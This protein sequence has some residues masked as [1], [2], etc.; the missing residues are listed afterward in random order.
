MQEIPVDILPKVISSRS[1]DDQKYKFEMNLTTEYFIEK[2][3]SYSFSESE[4]L[5]FDRSILDLIKK[6]RLLARFWSIGTF[7][8][9]T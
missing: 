7:T 6:F 5:A 2:Y 9:V 1:F 8:H 3:L 4:R